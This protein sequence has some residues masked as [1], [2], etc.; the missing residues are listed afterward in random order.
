MP[1]QSGMFLDQKLQNPARLSYEW[2]Y[3]HVLALKVLMSDDSLL[4]LSYNYLYSQ[5]IRV[6][7]HANTDL[8]QLHH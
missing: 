8:C 4:L 6:C 7:V 3:F 2:L 1:P 5:D